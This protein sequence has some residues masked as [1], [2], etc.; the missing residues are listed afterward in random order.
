M[1]SY[2]DYSRTSASYDRTRAA[3]GVE[4]IREA[5]SRNTVP[6]ESQVL[7]DA[8]CGTGQYTA[9][10]VNDIAQITAVD[11][12]QDMLSTARDKLRGATGSGR[13]VFHQASLDALPIDSQ[14]IDA[15]MVNQVLHHVADD[16]TQG[17]PA[18]QR[19]FAEF[20][21]VLKPG[22]MLVINSCSHTQLRS[23]F[24]FYQ[25]IP[26][27]IERICRRTCDLQVLGELL[28]AAGFSPAKHTVA[29]EIVMQ[30]SAYFRAEGVFDPDWRSGDSIWALATPDELEKALNEAQHHAEAGR[31]ESFMRRHDAE[32]ANVGQLTFSSAQK[33]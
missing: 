3:Q 30:D 6:L 31:L 4:I 1:S 24:W 11:L 33:Y 7:L 12:N 8:G 28:E 26:G 17:W 18:H 2:E 9:A 14:S 19:I 25:L 27:A 10:L 13:L 29:P 20:A 22:S 32:R 15:V 5:L 23:G 16:P 21:R